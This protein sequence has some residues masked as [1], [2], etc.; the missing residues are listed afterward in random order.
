MAKNEAVT[1]PGSEDEEAFRLSMKRMRE[2]R[3]WT[4]AELA[5]RMT[6]SGWSGMYQMT[7]GRMEKGVRPIRIGEARGLAKVFGVTVGMMIAPPESSKPVEALKN[8]V[9][10]LD[11]LVPRMSDDIDE[12]FFFSKVLL[13]GEIAAVEECGYQEWADEDLKVSIEGFLKR[14]RRRREETLRDIEDAV[15]EKKNAEYE[16]T[17][18]GLARAMRDLESDDGVDS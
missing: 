9:L 8:T 4:Q 3:G 7:I 14:A 11:D 5:K 10:K 13:P 1:G 12:H 15:M 18:A 6:D 2:E 16:H 17:R